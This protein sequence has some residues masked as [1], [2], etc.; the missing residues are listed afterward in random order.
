MTAKRSESIRDLL[1]TAGPCI[2]IVSSESKLPEAIKSVRK[3]LRERGEETEALLAPV[4]KAEQDLGAEGKKRSTIAI[5]CSP[6]FIRVLPVG[7][8]VKEIVKVNDRFD[9]R[10]LLAMGATER[11]F[12]IL[13]L[14]QKRTRILECT[15]HS[16]REV[17]FPAGFPESLG[18]SKQT[19]RPDHELDNRSSAGP[20]VGGMKGVMFGTSTDREKKDQYLLH[21]FSSVDKAVHVALT[22]HT[23]PLVAV[24]VESELALYRHV[25]TYP[26]LVEPG[27]HGSPDGMEGGEVHRRA[28]ELLQSRPASATV[29]ALGDFDKKVG[30]GHAST[31]IQDIVTAAFEG[32]VSHF[33]FQENAKYEGTFDAMRQ[34]VK[35]SDPDD[36]IEEGAYQTIMH[37]GE[38]LIM[39]GSA[40]PNGVAVCALFRYPATQAA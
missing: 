40:M 8:E 36:L 32:R 30:T 27:V 11:T 15:E 13:A 19:D 26:N 4:L 33:F 7:P 21:F 16:C 18:D 39:P 25:N 1:S 2:T 17:P 14:S 24:A 10:T 6:Q 38:A 35:H 9:V 31:R 29:E 34:R 28:L 22:D 20:D 5:L 23:K 12:H 3:L 37:K